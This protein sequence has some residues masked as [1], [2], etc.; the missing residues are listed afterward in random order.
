[1]ATKKSTDD[2]KPKKAAS[3]KPAEKSAVTKKPA[4]KKA[5]ATTKK[6]SSPKVEASVAAPVKKAGVRYVAKP[7]VKAGG[8][9]RRLGGE[10]EDRVQTAEAWKRGMESEYGKKKLAKPTHKRRK[11]KK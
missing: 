10:A 11:S 5:S 2:K 6:A 8:P 9:A 3:K 7:K 1:M 4:A